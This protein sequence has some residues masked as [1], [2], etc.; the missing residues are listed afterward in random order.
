MSD[1]KVFLNSN[2]QYLKFWAGQSGFSTNVKY[3]FE[4]VD[5]INLATLGTK[6]DMSNNVQWVKNNPRKDVIAEIPATLAITRV[7]TL[8]G[9]E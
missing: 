7:V 3:A 8:V 5:D 2:G 9:L 1:K 6:S 4:W